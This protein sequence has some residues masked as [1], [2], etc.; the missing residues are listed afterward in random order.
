MK[1]DFF[2]FLG[3]ALIIVFAL[4][5]YSFRARGIE[6]VARSQSLASCVPKDFSGL[7][8]PFQKVAIFEGRRIEIPELATDAKPQ[9]VLGVSQEERWV[10][11][12]L[13]E[14]KLKAWDGS[15]LFLETAVSTGLPGTPTP[16]G[17]FR[18]WIRCKSGLLGVCLI[19]I[20]HIP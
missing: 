12:D 15:G 16:I 9:N 10:E 7:M 5:A 17:E 11:V 1:K 6:N 13:S 18:I 14:Q 8:E 19:I 3:L 4:A 20:K 2:V